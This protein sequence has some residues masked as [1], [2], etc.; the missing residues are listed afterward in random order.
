MKKRVVSTDS[1][2]RVLALVPVGDEV[3]T[4]AAAGADPAMV[5]VLLESRAAYRGGERATIPFAP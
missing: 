2:A 4:V 5:F 3:R 1:G